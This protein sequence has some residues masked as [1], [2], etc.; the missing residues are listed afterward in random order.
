MRAVLWRI[1]VRDLRGSARHFVIFL[2]SLILG[3]ATIAAVGLL[4]ASAQQGI[5]NDAD[6]LR[7][8][9]I[10]VRTLYESPSDEAKA[11]LAQQGTTL[12]YVSLR[13]MARVAEKREALD[14]AMDAQI[15]ELKA[16]PE[17]YPLAGQLLTTPML[18]FDA[19]YG[20]QD[21]AY[22]AAVEPELLEMLALA[23]GDAI[24]LGEQRFTIRA[25]LDE[26]PDR[27]GAN[28]S[29]G[30]RIMVSREALTH[31]GLVQFGSLVNY[32]SLLK[33][34]DPLRLPEV[35]DT[36][37]QDYDDGGFQL[38]TT[39]NA[40]PGLQ[41]A[42][43]RLG[44]FLTFAAIATL[45]IGG[46]GIANAT[47]SYLSSRLLTIARFKCLGATQADTLLI[48]TVQMGVLCLG[49]IGIGLVIAIVIQQG[50][51]SLFAQSLPIATDAAITMYPLI[52]AA[53]YGICTTF[54]FSS[55]ALVSAVRTPPTTLLRHSAVQQSVQLHIGFK[56]GCILAVVALAIIALT[57]SFVGNVMLTLVFFIAFGAAALAFYVLAWGIKKL[58]GRYG[59]KQGLGIASRMALKNLARPHAMTTSF[60][61]S[62]GL[63]L[64]LM[65]ALGIIAANF[66]QQLRYAPPEEAPDFFLIDIQPSNYQFFKDDVSA[67]AGVEK[68]N[69]VPM[70]RGRIA[71]RNGEVLT[72]DMVDPKV[73]WALQG[74]RGI[75]FSEAPPE[76]NGITEGEWW[77]DDYDGEPLVS[78]GDEL[79][80]GMGI[81][82]GD[83][84]TF[85]VSG[86]N[87][88]ARV[89]N[90]REIDW[91][92]LQMNFGI[93][94][95]PNSMIDV[96]PLYLGTVHIE[97]AEEMNVLRHMMRTHPSVSVVR[98]KATLKRVSA[99]FASVATLILAVG[100]MTILA[101]VCVIFGSLGTTL[102]NRAYESLLLNVLGQ[103]K[104]NIRRIVTREM[105][106][107]C[108]SGVALALAM[109]SL[110]SYL[111]ADLMRLPQWLV[112]PEI[113][114]GG[115][116]LAC[117]LVVGLAAL[118]MR[119]ISTARPMDFLRNE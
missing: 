107:L 87:I 108:V 75:T 50:V 110:I 6:K 33:L 19:L 69:L 3:T 10:L 119:T 101:G 111:L 80:K 103:T 28:Y 85:N 100:G 17:S 2:F 14:D 67:Q 112:I 38:R 13:T 34:D 66:Y 89:A 27:L 88:H 102:R 42:L 98:I 7:G 47:K 64:T 104:A 32:V 12:E 5:Q 57:I 21:N 23:V 9:D 62:L 90:L 30:P 29:L 40:A 115:V 43:D 106:Y 44:M 95:S 39:E 65:A 92:T 20:K 24:M 51:L 74:E 86:Q 72:P 77:S 99:L 76:N 55:A 113:Y 11:Y 105:L 109:G 96:P 81:K 71:L 54:L 73:Q 52:I 31:T 60:S 35:E 37:M 36:L 59:H 70:V 68:L 56:L 15:A 53:L 26:E 78:F 41:R 84:M 97:E 63:S 83:T 1:A 25:V 16:V 22:G 45:L 46:I 118:L 58:A 82:V 49:G 61:L 91:T 116:V 117:V 114:L 79:A 93:I 94:L 48:Y 4:L 8:G 18:G